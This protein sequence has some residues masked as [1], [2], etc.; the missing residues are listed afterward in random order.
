[1]RQIP[2][3]GSRPALRVALAAAL[4]VLVATAFGPYRAELPWL[5]SLVV[6]QLRLQSE[7]VIGVWY[8]SM[9]FLGAS[10]LFAAAALRAH[11]AGARAWRA[12]GWG[13]F[14]GFTALLSLDEL[15]SLHE[16]LGLMLDGW[17]G[18]LAV[19]GAIVVGGILLFAVKVARE[20]R[21]VAALIALGAV[22]LATVPV[23]EW[24]E[25]NLGRD[26]VVGALL[27]EGTELAAALLFVAAGLLK[28]PPSGHP[29]LAAPRCGWTVVA[30]A[31]VAA[32][33]V[34]ALASTRALA[35]LP[36]RGGLGEPSHWFLAAPPFL[37]GVL[38]LFEGVPAGAGRIALGVVTLAM[39]A[40][41][42]A[43]AA[44][45]DE[46]LVGSPDARL[47]ADLLL[48]AACGFAAVLVAPTRLMPRRRLAGWLVAAFAWVVVPVPA[49]WLATLAASGLALFA[50]AERRADVAGRDAGAAEPQAVEGPV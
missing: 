3:L 20:E 17:I 46:I 43:S 13:A 24:I 12:W 6:H 18:V 36:D 23:Q 40:D 42:G 33:A 30:A 14:A 48:L 22:L 21:A 44:I 16:R 39:S 25:V 11:Q 27:E 15:G 34:G 41:A 7:N 5:A 35:F 29:R 31:V 37:A 4:V 28:L 1:M 50:L 47:L 10:V 9:V 45:S 38:L 26:P 8:A 2:Q 32:A 49:K 19:P